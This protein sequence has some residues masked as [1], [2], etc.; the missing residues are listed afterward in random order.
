[1]TTTRKRGAAGLAALLTTLLV[2]GAGR[3]ASAAAP[4]PVLVATAD[5][6]GHLAPCEA[7]PTHRGLGGIERRAT[8]VAG[9]REDHA[10]LLLLDAGNALYGG[11][12]A[13]SGG[14]A[15]VAA[16][17]AMRYDAFNVSYRDL[18]LGREHALDLM[19]AAPLP[20]VSANLLDAATGEPIFRPFVV[21]DAGGTRVAVVGVTDTPPAL[22]SLPHLRKQLAGVTIRPA[23]EALQEWLPRAKEEADTVV[24]LYY[25]TARGARA[26]RDKFGP[27]IAAIV[28]GGVRP[29][30]LPSGGVPLVVAAAEHGKF[31]AVAHLGPDAAAGV[32]RVAQL[33]VEPSIQPDAATAKALA[34]HALPSLLVAPEREREEG[35]A[36]ASV[37]PPAQSITAGGIAAETPQPPQPTASTEAPP[38]PVTSGTMKQDVDAPRRVVAK[39]PNEPRGLAGVGLT[40]EQVNAAIDRGADFLWDRVVTPRAGFRGRLGENG[41]YDLLVCLALV[42]ANAHRRIPEFDAA[43]RAYL[44]TI[45]SETVGVYGSGVLCMVL[46]AYG[47]AE[48]QPLLRRASRY[49]LE[50]QSTEGCWEYYPKLA[51]DVLLDPNAGKALQVWGGRPTDGSPAEKWRRQTMP[52]KYEG[53]DNSVMQYALLGLHAAARSGVEVPRE[54]WQRTL[55]LYRS[56][57]GPEGGWG[58]VGATSAGT[59]SMT[60][61]GIYGVALCRH[62]LGEKAPAEDE[63]IERGLGWMTEKFSVSENPGA[64][65]VW[66]Y[67]YLYSLERAARTAG[68]EFVG[69]HEWYPLGAKFLVDAQK[70]DGSWIEPGSY[71]TRP[72]VSTSFAL[73]F[74]TRGT[75][76]LT[77]ARPT[78]G[79]GTLKTGI[80]E[81]AAPRVYLIFDCSGSML[82]EV[83]GRPK[84]DVAREA[85]AELMNGLPDR[86]QVA[87]RVYG[88]R[89]NA[90]EAGADEDTELLVPMAPI[91]RSATAA[92]VRRLRARGKTPLARSIAAAAKDLAG[93]TLDNRC[94]VVLITDGGEDTRPPGDPVAAAEDLARMPGITLHVVGFDIGREDWGRQL[95]AIAKAGGGRY[96]AAGNAAALRGELRAAILRTP[97]QF[98]L[99]ADDGRAVWRGSFGE[100]R[101]LP[102]GRYVFATEFAGKRFNEPVWVNTSDTTAVLFDAGKIDVNEPAGAPPGREAPR[103]V[104]ETPPVEKPAATHAG[105]RFCTEC[106]AGLAAGAKFCTKCGVKVAA[107]TGAR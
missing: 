84:F 79:N 39:Q 25:G 70:E 51:P 46:E 61:A 102:E 74:L 17:A 18:R 100:S 104:V 15:V 14:A 80:V 65:T 42:K 43:L 4:G 95:R 107:P 101:S 93:S 7:C 85:L 103:E 73:L 90:R 27:A 87:L 11:E 52:G 45:Q 41:E 98:T 29:D 64:G 28:V 34:P 33:P 55:D 31:V 94:A 62:H 30:Q 20:A 63:A 35:P 83:G 12:S 16:Y 89:K 59:G 92:T 88:H 26:I 44:P 105:R 50:S 2:P 36:T 58:Y 78:G 24:V 72:E 60:C 75:A 49:L 106:G 66:H 53:G 32:P 23:A 5:T 37:A 69:P 91:D 86:T 67:Y 57:Q 21:K 8:L 68:A 13:R 40:A 48:F 76:L 6:E 99:S 97:E 19:N 1:M 10:A 9:L 56:R 81:P 47:D 71:E 22:A 96:W 82:V 38:K 77:Q 3:P 54:A